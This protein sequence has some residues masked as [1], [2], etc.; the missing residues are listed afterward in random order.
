MIGVYATCSIHDD[1]LLVSV[2]FGTY[3]RPMIESRSASGL[4]GDVLA[5]FASACV[6]GKVLI[7][8]SPPLTI[9]VAT[10][11]I[12]LLAPTGWSN[13]VRVFSLHPL[14]GVP[15]RPGKRRKTRRP[16]PGCL[17][18]LHQFAVRHRTQ[19]HA[20]PGT[21]GERAAAPEA[22]RLWPDEGAPL[23]PGPL[24]PRKRRGSHPAFFWRTLRPSMGLD[25]GTYV[26]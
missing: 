7:S 22:R 4:P 9:V 13:D 10:S 14:V 26:P 1:V 16:A 12:Y 6:A 8:L 17:A 24:A 3:M 11:P 23:T 18:A 20:P 15:Q 19:H 25:G 2:G 5:A 21:S